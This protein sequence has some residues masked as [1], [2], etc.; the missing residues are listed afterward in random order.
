MRP[1]TINGSVSAL[2]FLFTVTLD[3]GDMARHL[4]FV[5]EPRKVPVVLSPDE[6]ARLS[7]GG[8]GTEVQGSA[9]RGL[10]GGI[11]RLRS[12]VSVGP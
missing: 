7:R 4:T 6:V 10:W 1:P 3:R 5:H 11:A 2:R 12:R 9:R 8:A